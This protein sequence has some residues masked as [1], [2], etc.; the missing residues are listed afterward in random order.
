MSASSSLWLASLIA[1]LCV[2]PAWA[3]EHPGPVAYFLCRNQKVV[4]TLRIERQADGCQVIYAKEGKDKIVGLA[5]QPASC[6]QVLGNIHKNLAQAGWRCR[7]V[8]RSAQLI[9]TR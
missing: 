6:E 8:S 5:R 1:A 4:R 3:E 2:H 9:E 7:D